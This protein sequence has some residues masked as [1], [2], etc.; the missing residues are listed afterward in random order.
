MKV[1]TAIILCA[2]Y[3]KRVNPIT[4]DC[5]KPLLK[6]N[7]TTLLENTINIIKKIGIKNIY[8]NSFYLK[9]KLKDY[10]SNNKF[11]ININIIDDGKYLL[12]TGGGIKNILQNSKDK[13]F[14]VFNPDTLWDKTYLKY[15]KK[16]KEQYEKK[17]LKN[18][19]LVVDK[20]LSFDKNLT[21]DFDLID[22]RL[23][24]NKKKKYIFTGFQIINRYAFDNMEKKI[25]SI[26]D[27]WKI[28]LKKN[29]LYGFE[30]RSKFMHITDL[31]IYKKISK[32]Y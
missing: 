27:I 23:D 22:D 31:K 28:Q 26:Q 5:P 12:G 25:F 1:K 10:L 30:S 17:K 16:M 14:V 24:I 2:G 4:L 29:C 18:F 11:N 15:I 19:L 9:N 13:S 3:G 32:N 20:K 6:I 21:G 7:K 8:I